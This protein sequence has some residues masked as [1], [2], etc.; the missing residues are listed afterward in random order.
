MTAELGIGILMPGQFISFPMDTA[1]DHLPRYTNLGEPVLLLTARNAGGLRSFVNGHRLRLGPSAV[2]FTIN[3]YPLVNPALPCA[4]DVGESNT[5]HFS[6]QNLIA[7][8]KATRAAQAD[9]AATLVAE[10]DL[11]SGET[12]RSAELP[13]EY[14][15]EGL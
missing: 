2:A 5:W 9:G 10:V 12:V 6:L 3:D 14:L 13:C 1:K 8:V 4:L 11:G 7:L 15:G